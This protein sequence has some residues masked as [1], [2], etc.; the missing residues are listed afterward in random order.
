MP[1]AVR[2]WLW[3]LSHS[4]CVFVRYYVH[5]D[6][7]GFQELVDILGGVEIT[8]ERR[9]HYVDKAQGLEVDL[10]PGTQVLDGAKAL[11]Y[12]RYCDG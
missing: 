4:W 9:M 10:F 3:R 1:T 7:Q 2:S 5:T 6:F 11:Q 8:V 12:V